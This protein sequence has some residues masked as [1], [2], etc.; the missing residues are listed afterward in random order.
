LK[1][2]KEF[3]PKVCGSQVG[4][5]QLLLDSYLLSTTTNFYKPCPAFS[6]MQLTIVAVLCW[7]QVHHLQPPANFLSQTQQQP[8]RHHHQQLAS[9]QSYSSSSGI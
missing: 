3:P 5:L 8:Q 7:L 1:R 2:L 9:T 4:A 6:R